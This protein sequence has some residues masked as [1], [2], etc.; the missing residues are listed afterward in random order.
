M[1]ENGDNK[2]LLSTEQTRTRVLETNLAQLKEEHSDLNDIIERLTEELPFN[3]L[4][5]SRLKKRKLGLKD[6]ISKIEMDM[7]PDIIA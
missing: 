2:H 5:V 1:P 4:Q 7:R 6:A 3:Q